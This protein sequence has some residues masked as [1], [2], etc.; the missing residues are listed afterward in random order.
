MRFRRKYTKQYLS[1]AEV[2]RRLYGAPLPEINKL[3]PPTSGGALE[4][5]EIIN[6]L[7]GTNRKGTVMPDLQSALKNAIETWEPTP[8]NKPVQSVQQPEEQ[9]MPKVTFPIRNNVTRATFNYI[10]AHPQTTSQAAVRDLEK[11]G[12]KASSVTALFAQMTRSNLIVRDVNGGYRAL[13]DEYIPMKNTQKRVAPKKLIKAH[14]KVKPAKATAPQSEGIAALQPEATSKRAITTII[15]SR[16][17]EDILNDMNV[18]QAKELYD[19]LKQLF[20]G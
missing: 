10:H 3:P 9:P 18:R 12:Y 16:T 2:E 20:G 7:Q 11:Q 14:S 4:A 1:A 17:P 6:K 13:V 5:K 15:R 8:T 19:Y